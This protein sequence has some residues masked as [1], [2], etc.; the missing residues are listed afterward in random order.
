MSS[1]PVSVCQ[2]LQIPTGLDLFSLKYFEKEMRIN[3]P[4]VTHIDQNVFTHVKLDDE[5]WELITKWVLV[6]K[7]NHSVMT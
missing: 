1:Y 7:L 4:S 3:M 2:V 5:P 6:Q